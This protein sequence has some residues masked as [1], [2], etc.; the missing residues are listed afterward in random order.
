MMHE[1]SE[2]DGF[3]NELASVPG[4]E[5]IF[6]PYHGADERAATCRENL[7]RYLAQMRQAQPRVLL[8][9][10]A[11]GYRGARLTG[12]PITSERVMLAADNKFGLFG[13]G[14]R[15]TSD[16]E[17]RRC[18]EH[19]QHRMGRIIRACAAGPPCCGAV[20]PSTHT[21]PETPTR[22]ALLACQSV[23]LACRFSSRYTVCLV[24]NSYWQWEARRRPRSK[25][26][27]G[28]RCLC[29]TRHVVASRSS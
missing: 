23:V 28:I 24:L 1:T 9:S 4:T 2:F 13:D 26:W 20:S 5:K 14:F 15:Q 6:S 22:I 16:V 10:E 29:V 17:N 7:A 25:N 12:V 21:L 27:V 11:Y 18:R 19:L 3:L 8:V